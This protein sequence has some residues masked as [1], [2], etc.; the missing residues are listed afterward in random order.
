MKIKYLSSVAILIFTCFLLTKAETSQQ[1]ENSPQEWLREIYKEATSIH[2]GMTRAELLEK[3]RTD[4]GIQRI[5]ESRFVLKACSLIKIEVEFETP[6]GQ[7]YKLKPDSQ[8]IITK[9][10]QPYLE[11]PAK[12]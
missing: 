9:I 11:H 1:K 12:D 2:K 3:Y 6:Y 8:L 10:S 7:A 5:P 4:G